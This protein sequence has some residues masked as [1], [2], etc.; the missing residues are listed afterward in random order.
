[1]STE[2][3]RD[4]DHSIQIYSDT[5]S[6]QSNNVGSSDEVGSCKDGSSVNDEE[7][8]MWHTD[9]KSSPTTSTDPNS[10]QA[11][12]DSGHLAHLKFDVPSDAPNGAVPTHVQ[13]GVPIHVRKA[14]PSHDPNQ[15]AHDPNQTAHDSSLSRFL[16][17]D[18][19]NSSLVNSHDGQQ[20]F[21]NL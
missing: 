13:G 19:E 21:E 5:Q 18:E 4:N 16:S 1:M 14:V 15:T 17:D 7:I 9:K 11:K 20:E 10:F 6:T 3:M 12:V 8:V 2:S